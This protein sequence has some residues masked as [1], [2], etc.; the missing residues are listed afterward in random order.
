MGPAP[1][2]LA[3]WHA[4][5]EPSSGAESPSIGG[6]RPVG[7]RATARSYSDGRTAGANGTSPMPMSEH[8][9][10]EPSSGAGSLLRRF[11]H[12]EGGL[13]PTAHTGS[14]TPRRP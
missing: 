14:P 7:W 10:L 2:M 1:C 5:L 12:K 9:W 3:H 4:W 13:D 6:S 11:P 8:A